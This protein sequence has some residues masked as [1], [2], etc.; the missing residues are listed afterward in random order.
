MFDNP[1]NRNRVK[2]IGETLDKLE[3]SASSNRVTPD[4]VAQMLLPVLDRFAKIK[5]SGDQMRPQSEIVSEA[6]MQPVGH[7]NSAVYPHGRPHNW[8]TIKECAE[9]APL[10][11]LTV[12]LTVYMNR[13]EELTND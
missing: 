6:S 3:K 13:V 10:K 4:E 7:L 9:N 8:T 2:H 5:N 11:D 12:A 1:T